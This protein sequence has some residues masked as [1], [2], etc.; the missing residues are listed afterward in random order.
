MWGGRKNI[1]PKIINVIKIYIT[2]S[3]EQ[4]GGEVSKRERERE[5]VSKEREIERR[6]ESIMILHGNK[7]FISPTRIKK[8]S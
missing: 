2:H 6:G 5:K 8:V 4:E 7:R 1:D 3:Y